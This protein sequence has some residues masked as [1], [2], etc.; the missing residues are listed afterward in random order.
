MEKQLIHRLVDMI[1]SSDE[2][3]NELAVTIFCD[4]TNKYEDYW[5]L[6]TFFDP[7]AII[8]ASR[9]Q[10]IFNRIFNTIDRKTIEPFL[11][12]K[13][14]CYKE[15]SST[16]VGRHKVIERSCVITNKQEQKK[17]LKQR[18]WHTKTS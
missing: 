17:Q 12:E 18:K 4:N 2:E 7:S 15:E 6:R 3:M 14:D 16:R 10:G 11:S 9:E 8:L 5:E 1:R 13:R